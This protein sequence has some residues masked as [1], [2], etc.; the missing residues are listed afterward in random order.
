MRE[1]DPPGFADGVFE[2]HFYRMESLEMLADSLLVAGMTTT[3][4]IIVVLL[5]SRRS[6]STV[7]LSVLLAA[8]FSF[9][10]Y[11][12]AFLHH[13]KTLGAIAV[14]FGYGMGFLLGPLILFYTRSLVFQSRRLI[15]PLAIH[16]LP[17]FCYWISVSIPL[18]INI[19]SESI[20]A[21]WGQTIA[22]NSEILNIIENT[23][24]LVYSVLAFKFV[25]RLRRAS[26]EN[27]SS[28]SR[29][30]V[31]WCV[32]LIRGLSVVVVVDI[33][34]SIYEWVFPPTEIIWNI[35]LVVAILLVV[36]IGMIGYRGIF[37][38]QLFIPPHL[39][40]I[41]NMEKTPEPSGNDAPGHY[42]L[43]AQREDIEAL[44][45]RLLHAMESEKAYLNEGLTLGD[46]STM[47]D[48]TDKKLSELL[49]RHFQT[50]FYDF[51]NSYRLE[52]VKSK[53]ADS[54]FEHLTLL[55]MAFESGF[56]SKTSFN[57]I[58]K[59]KVGMSPSAYKKKL[60][61]SS[62]LEMERVAS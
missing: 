38:S 6:L 44:K 26:L 39:L 12:Y 5:K 20:F 51:V 31:S 27:Y 14:F 10:L 37:Q 45:S 21:G 13:S 15:K 32:L 28:L 29:R 43:N 41:G 33:A 1:K 4:L 52:A 50:T 23:Y 47:V 61:E 59:Q 9:L 3:A 49:N 30:D 18:S 53:M 62:M 34:L 24:L 54:N 7:L 40:P 22:D 25:K 42:H 55:G 56:Q 35:G 58:F 19:Y 8:C 46:L 48:L 11:Y 36:F 57:R 17:W 16:L 60:A 2:G